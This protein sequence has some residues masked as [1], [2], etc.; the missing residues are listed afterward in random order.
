MTIGGGSPC[1]GCTGHV[2]RL[3]E[4]TSRIKAAEGLFLRDLGRP[5]WFSG[6]YEESWED[7][8]SLPAGK[9]P[10]GTSD[11]GVAPDGP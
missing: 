9:V 4:S 3:A 2:G 10:A 6:D 11:R 8:R 5:W 1:G 7:L